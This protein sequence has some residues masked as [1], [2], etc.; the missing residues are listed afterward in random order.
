MQDSEVA[1]IVN[2]N[3]ST[4]L[5]YN[6]DKKLET[7]SGGVD[8]TGHTETDTLNV[9]GIATAQKFIGDGSELR[10][11]RSTELVSYASASDISNSALSISGISTY[12]EVGI[13]TGTYATDSGDRFGWGVACSADGNTIIVSADTDETGSTNSTGVVYVYD[14]V[15][16]TFNEVGILTGSYTDHSDDTFGY[17]VATSAD[18]KT[19]VVSDLGED[20]DG[21][22]GVVYVFDRV[23]NNFNQVG[24]L[25]GSLAASNNNNN[26][27][28]QSVATSADGKT[29]I[30][31]DATEDFGSI[32]EPGVVYVFDRVGNNFN[33]VGILTGS[34][35]SDMS[36]FGYSVATSD[37]GNTIVVGASYD[38]TNGNLT[39]S[40]YVFDRVGNN[41]NEVGILTG[42]YSN[43]SADFFGNSVTCSA[44]GKTIVVGARDDEVPGSSNSSGVVYVFDR[45]GNNFNEV[46]ILTGTYASDNGDRF[47]K[48]VATSADGKTIVVGAWDDEVPG[49]GSSSGVVYTFNRQGN[50][51][52]EV[53]ILTG[54]ASSGSSEF[55]GSVATSADGK[56]I[57]VG[58]HGTGTGNQVAYVFDQERE[59]YVFS[60]TNGNIGIGSAQPTAKL[61]VNGNT[62]LDDLNV[63]GVSTF[64]DDVRFPSAG[65]N[66]LGN[67]RYDKSVGEL[68][69]SGVGADKIKSTYTYGGDSF[70]VYQNF[71]KSISNSE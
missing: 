52:N 36:F 49:S 31:G 48:S 11:L 20:L 8:V 46:G 15:G 51:F 7:T 63:S 37:D 18:G 64:Q 26:A 50:T 69:F 19:I 42:T 10:G 70:S 30:V 57:I 13:L 16:N 29:I 33:E 3:T 1:F 39:G 47:G 6:Y 32:N 59:T 22:E 9:S 28:G 68:K 66:G 61:D 27:F 58:A 67:I 41:F 60:D 5:R 43:N 65:A 62:E 17:R 12:N 2:P 45:E 55:G 14:R 56:N 71:S 4:E 40:T 21:S 44:D 38:D 54:S 23:G 25:T 35:S 34:N 53:G 24:I